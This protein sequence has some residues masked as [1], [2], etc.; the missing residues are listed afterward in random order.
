[1]KGKIKVK[2]LISIIISAFIIFAVILGCYFTKTKNYLKKL[3]VSA[4]NQRA[5]EYEQ[6]KDGDENVEQTEN[7]K[8]NAFF[9]RD[10]DS[11]GN[12]DTLY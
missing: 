1:M 11:D 3:N 9:L 2:E 7:V 12:A 4:E 5:M 10:L 6:Y 8:F